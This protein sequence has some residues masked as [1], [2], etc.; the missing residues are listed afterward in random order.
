MSNKSISISSMFQMSVKSGEDEPLLSISDEDNAHEKIWRKVINLINICQLDRAMAACNK[1]PSGK[2]KEALLAYI[3]AKEA[4]NTAALAKLEEF[5]T[6]P[7]NVESNSL[8][9]LLINTQLAVLCVTLATQT[10]GELSKCYLKTAEIYASKVHDQATKKLPTIQNLQLKRI[11]ATLLINTGEG[12]KSLEIL[13][14]ICKT[15]EQ[16]AEGLKHFHPDIPIILDLI[17]QASGMQQQPTPTSSN[18]KDLSE[19]MLQNSSVK[20]DISEFLHLPYKHYNCAKGVS[21]AITDSENSI[22]KRMLERLKLNDP[23]LQDLVRE[24]NTG[25]RRVPIIIEKEIAIRDS[26]VVVDDAP[27]DLLINK[28]CLY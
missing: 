7:T 11:R 19:T 16:I 20:V 24:D 10:F 15:W 2:N 8:R 17:K 21:V 13:H 5:S 12:R 27:T 9:T 26:F 22:T 6:P 18:N 1:E 25:K 14:E 28:S 3:D 4:P 23:S